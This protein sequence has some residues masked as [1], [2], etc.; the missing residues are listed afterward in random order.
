MRARLAPFF[1]LL[2]AFGVAFSVAFGVVCFN[3][4]D[5]RADDAKPSSSGENLTSH[6][7]FSLPMLF[8]VDTALAGN[9]VGT[10]F[11][12]GF[13]PEYVFAWATGEEHPL[14][15][16][17]G[18]YAEFSG[19]TGTSQIWLGGGATVVG[20]FGMV[21]VA[22]SGGLE[23]DWLH[24]APNAS[25]VVGVFVG[26]RNAGSDEC[27]DFPFGLRVDYH[28]PLGPLPSVIQVSAQVDWILGL[29]VGFFGAIVKGMRD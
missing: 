17:I 6:G 23:I 7:F 25:P 20:Y 28:P 19:S 27:C 5:A 1:A 10:G 3:A 29:G 4:S 9:E 8:G 13:R 2:V 14:G 16:G 24:A 22:A 18:P 26:V 11:L 12:W 15:F 21:A